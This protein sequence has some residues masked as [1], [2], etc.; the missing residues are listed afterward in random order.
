LQEQEQA[1]V[2]LDPAALAQRI[3][4]DREEQHGGERDQ[5]Q[6]QPVDA[7]VV[8]DTGVRDPRRILGPGEPAARGVA[9]PG[10]DYQAEVGGGR[11][12]PRPG[13]DAP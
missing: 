8:A 2:G 4:R 12:D 10:D 7:D 11:G 1:D 6:G 9:D 5:R 13:E 3:D